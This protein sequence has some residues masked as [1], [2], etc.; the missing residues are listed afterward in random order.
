M[1]VICVLIFAYLP[2][3]SSSLI[4]TRANR[5]Y[6]PLSFMHNWIIIIWLKG[7]ACNS[8]PKLSQDQ[9]FM[10]GKRNEQGL[11]SRHHAAHHRLGCGVRA[12]ADT[13]PAR[14]SRNGCPDTPARSEERRVG[15]ECRSRWS[16]YH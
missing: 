11:H 13:A 12:V 14:G 4:G 2:Q 15:K 5:I 16:P 1:R 7:V 10:G 8:F 9:D 3:I 6:F